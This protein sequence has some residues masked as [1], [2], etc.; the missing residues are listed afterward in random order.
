MTQTSRVM[1]LT[2]SNSVFSSNW[3]NCFIETGASNVSKM[4][5][6]QRVAE[7]K[8]KEKAK[9]PDW[10]ASTTGE[11]K[12]V[13]AEDKIASRIAAEVLRDNAKLRAVHSGPSIKKLLEREAKK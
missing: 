11:K 12:V 6:S 5:Y 10:D 13:S 8:K 2:V 4:S 7:E 3:I 9:Q 1:L